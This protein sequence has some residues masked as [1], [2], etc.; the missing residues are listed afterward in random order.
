MAA[1]FPSFWGS[2]MPKRLLRYVLQRV[3][4]LEDEALDLEK[5]DLAIGRESFVEFRD[6]GIK[7]QVSGG[8]RWLCL[9]E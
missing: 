7:H 4:Y 1:F 5:L 3:D 2:D 6:V 8:P 9:P